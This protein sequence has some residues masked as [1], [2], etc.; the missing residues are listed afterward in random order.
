MKIFEKGNKKR[1]NILFIVNS[2][3]FFISHRI[4]LYESL[5][6]DGYTIKVICGNERIKDAYINKSKY[7]NF[8]NINFSR[9]EKN[10][11]KILISIIQVIKFSYKF[12]PQNIHTVSPIGNLIG[13]LA[14]IFFKN[15]HL[16]TAISGRGT[17]YIKKDIYTRIIKALFSVCE[18]VY[19]NKYRSSTITQNSYDLEEIK[20][21]QI[22]KKHN[23][24]VFGS[25]VDLSIFSPD[26]KNKIYDVCFIG[27]LSEDKGII[28]FIDAVS[29]AHKNNNHLKFLVLGEMQHDDKKICNYLINQFK[30]KPFIEYIGFKK[31]IVDY[32]NISKIV[33]LPSKRE[34]MPRVVL[35][36]S[37]CGVPSITYNVIGCN[38]AIVED[39][40]GYLVNDLSPVLLAEKIIE[41]LNNKNYDLIKEST[42]AFAEKNFSINSIINSHKELYKLF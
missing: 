30:Q 20:K 28:D 19:L 2:I 22:F 31:N 39:K 12:K 37:A 11:L 3:N 23:K 41:V 7:I 34:G 15:T 25:G 29:I 40:N 6:K 32:L 42:R 24:L 27:R 35:E 16:I 14:A 4:E 5:K 1:K 9:T 17:L 13:G 10:P 36:A 38:E 21:K 33:C 8:S 26:F 18:F